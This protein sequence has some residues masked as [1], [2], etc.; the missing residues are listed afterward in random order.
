[1][2]GLIHPLTIKSLLGT[3]GTDRQ[4]IK[5]DAFQITCTYKPCVLL[6]KTEDNF[7]KQY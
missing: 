2:I 7:I 6:R 5:G 1:M 4:D 3:D